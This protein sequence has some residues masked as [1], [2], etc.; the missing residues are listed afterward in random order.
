MKVITLQRPAECSDC[1]AL[2]PAGTR[3]RYYSADK[4]YC[5][6]HDEPAARE[7]AAREPAET[8]PLFQDDNPDT[9]A[10]IQ[11]FEEVQVALSNLIHRLRGGS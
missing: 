5:E 8:G 6:T 3:A 9:E 7:T 4:I 2:L 1:G 11:F 10:W